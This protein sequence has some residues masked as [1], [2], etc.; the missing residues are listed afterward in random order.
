MTIST[1]L[2]ESVGPEGQRTW[3]TIPPLEKRMV[4]RVERMFKEIREHLPEGCLVLHRT[5]RIS[6]PPRRFAIDLVRMEKDADTITS[7]LV[8]LTAG[9]H[10]D[11]E[12]LCVDMPYVS[13][14][15]ALRWPENVRPE[16]LGLL[17]DGYCL[18]FNPGRP[19]GRDDAWLTTH[20]S[21]ESPCAII[22]TI[23]NTQPLAQSWFD[24]E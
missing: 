17:S 13:S 23:K 14:E 1:S 15:L 3:L 18:W 2:A 10:S 12:K 16:Q 21:G 19:S 5:S 9:Q 22:H 6:N 4:R 11:W 20:L 7:E 8:P 24:G